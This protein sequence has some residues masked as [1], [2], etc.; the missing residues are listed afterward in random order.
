[1]EGIGAVGSKLPAD[2]GLPRCPC[3]GHHAPFCSRRLEAHRDSFC[4]PISSQGYQY[5]DGTC[6]NPEGVINRSKIH[7]QTL[8]DD[9]LSGGKKLDDDE[10]SSYV[11]AGL[12][13]YYNSVVSSI[14]TRV[15]LISFGELYSQLIAH[16]NRLDLQNGGQSQSSVNNAS[17]GRSGF[18]RGRGGCSLSPRGG[19]SNG[20]RGCGNFF[21]KPKNKFP[22]CQLCGETNHPIFK[23]FKR[24]NP[25]YMGEEKSANA[26]TSYGIDTNWY[27]DFGA[28]DHVTE[29]LDKLLMKDTYHGGDQIYTASGLGMRIKHIGHCTIHTQYHNLKLNHNLHVLQSSKNLESIHQ[30]TSDNNIFFE[31]HPD[32][33]FIKDQK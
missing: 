23:C 26:T 17:R 7:L 29:D 14:T 27:A 24:F 18:F 31:L 28:T 30:I 19:G 20:G 11:L 32:F 15:E 5:L 2:I 9:M 25:N 33:F 22:P 13:A 6:H 16:E 8:A 12:D 1:V 3:P 4:V 10:F 21:G